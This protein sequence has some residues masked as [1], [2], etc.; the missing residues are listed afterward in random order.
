MK[1][2]IPGEKMKG[3]RNTSGLASAS[4][5]GGKLADTLRP[6][7]TQRVWLLAVIAQ[8][9]PGALPTLLLYCSYVPNLLS[10]TSH[11]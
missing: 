7:L 4:R 3:K 1:N 6:G 5:A 2:I 8:S 11:I 10:F 9:Q